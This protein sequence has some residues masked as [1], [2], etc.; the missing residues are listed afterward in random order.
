MNW[1]IETVWEGHGC[2]LNEKR[3]TVEKEWGSGKN[4]LQNIPD[5]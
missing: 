3:N 5:I 1:G 2:V 4:V